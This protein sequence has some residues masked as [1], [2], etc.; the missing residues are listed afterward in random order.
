MISSGQRRELF[1]GA[2]DCRPEA[3]STLEWRVGGGMTDGGAEGTPSYPPIASSSK[4]NSGPNVM[5]ANQQGFECSCHFP[6][7]LPP[8]EQWLGPIPFL[9][10]ASGCGAAW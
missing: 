7:L 1:A 3:L 9:G 2:G 10:L 5:G 8:G 6:A 4:P